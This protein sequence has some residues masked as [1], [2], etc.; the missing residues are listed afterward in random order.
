MKMGRQKRPGE[1]PRKSDPSKCVTWLSRVIL[2]HSDISKV[3][4]RIARIT[5][6]DELDLVLLFSSEGTLTITSHDLNV[7]STTPGPSNRKLKES[8]AFSRKDTKFAPSR[9]APLEGA[10][11]VFVEEDNKSTWLRACGV[12]PDATVVPLGDISLPIHP[13]VREICSKSS[14]QRLT[15]D[16]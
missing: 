11:V 15:Q 13:K 2:T 1:L 3:P 4:H 12:A 7:L 6:V 16:G 14:E 8:F 5:S 9:T 10:I